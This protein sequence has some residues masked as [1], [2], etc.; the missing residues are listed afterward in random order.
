MNIFVLNKNP[1][2]AARMLCDKHVV[3]MILESAQM[4]CTAHLMTGTQPKKIP[5]KATHKNHPC[6]KWTRESLGNYK[7]LVK[8]A[9]EL[10]KEYKRRYKKIHKCQEIIKW[11]AKNMPNIKKKKQT[12]FVQAMPNKYKV[13]GNAVKAYQAYY[14]GEKLRFCK[15]KIEKR[16]EWIENY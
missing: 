1:R 2:K 15:W 13:K 7:W 10:C 9:L 4:L 3:K 16:G 12:E 6:T 5:Y 14:V 8:H 11:C